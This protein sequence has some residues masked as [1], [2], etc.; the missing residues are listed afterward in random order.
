MLGYKKNLRPTV[1]PEALADGRQES[2]HALEGLLGAVLLH[3]ADGDDDDDGEGDGGG[4]VKLP[5]EQ[6][7][8]GR[9]EEQQDEWV[10]ELLQVFLPQRIG[11]SSPDLICCCHEFSMSEL[12]HFQLSYWYMI[13]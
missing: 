5:H 9:G 6:R 2:V 10:V 3:E 1:A 7:D 13:F 11:V 12:K 4:V 8:D